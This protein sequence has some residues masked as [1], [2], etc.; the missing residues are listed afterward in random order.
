MRKKAVSDLGASIF[1][2]VL[3]TILTVCILYPLL[4]TITTSFKTYAEFLK[5]PF[6]ITF[7]HPENYTTAWVEG[8]IG[9]LLGNSL[10][11]VITSVIGHVLSVC[12][13]SYAIGILRFKG[14][15]IIMALMLSGMFLT[16]EVTSI[17]KLL[18]IRELKLLNTLWALIVPYVLSP[19]GMAVIIMSNFMKR[20]PEEVIEAGE[21]DGAG[22]G[23]L[24]FHIVLPMSM[25]IIA[26][27]AIQQFNCVWNDFMWPLIAL[28]RNQT[29]WTIPLGLI[30][31]QGM[32]NS[33]YGELCA[34]LV[35]MMLPTITIYACFSKYFLEGAAAGAVKG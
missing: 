4:F 30:R 20:L 35:I 34:G 18:L 1:F 6:K 13:I 22:F 32:N 24:F 3:L 25:P 2:A 17:P 15:D 23:H 27:T 29:V 26:F 14:S 31:F 19:G 8:E 11:V 7:T 28:A 10:F 9:T 21:L 33:E 16:S 5:N 12:L